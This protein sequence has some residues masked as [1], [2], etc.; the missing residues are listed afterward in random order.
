MYLKK[1]IM[2]GFKSFA[3][4]TV[5]DFEDG[6]TAI[7]GPN[8]S[9]KSNILDALRWVMGEMSAKTLRGAN[10]QQIIFAGTEARKPLNF[11]EVSLVL[12]NTDRA[13]P[14]DFDELVVTR[15]VFR[16]G[17]SVYMI[18]NA[19]CRL[20]DVQE[21]FMDT[22]IGRGGYSMIGQGNVAQILSTKAEDRRDFFEGAAGVSK[23]KHRK[24]EAERKLE[25][26]NDNLTRVNDI[27]AELQSQIGP[28]ENQSKK[29]K[30]Y[31]EYYEEYK[32][33]DVSMSVITLKKNTELAEKAKEA[34]ETVTAEMEDLRAKGDETTRR[35][36]ELITLSKE[37]DEEKEERNRSLS[38]CEEQRLGALNDITIANNN[39]A[40]NTKNAERIDREIELSKKR[41]A[42]MHSQIAA[43]KEKI[44]ENKKT[45][46]EMESGFADVSDRNKA[47]FDAVNE[48]KERLSK[49]REEMS[50]AKETAT[51]KKANIEGAEQMRSEYISRREE[52]T[53]EIS[54]K[55]ANTEQ[56]SKRIAEN[57]KLAKDAEEK[58]ISMQG[59]VDSVNADIGSKND[60][61]QKVIAE[62]SELTVSNNSMTSKKRILEGMENEYEGFARSVKLVLKA[63][64]LK[65]RSIYGTLSGLVEVDKEYVVAIE[66]ALSGALQNIV[67]EDED[68]AKAA[69]RFLKEQHGG[70][71]TFLPISSVKSR[72]LDNERE[73]VSSDGV[74]GI[75]SDLVKCDRKYRG[76]VENL[77]GRTVVADNIDNAITLSKKFG[78]KF[79]TVTIAGEVFNAG[80]SISGGS[81]N[82]QSG[83]LSRAN[84][85][86]ELAEDISK[87]GRRL[88]E[89]AKA[90]EE[91]D[92]EIKNLETRLNSYLPL[93]R[94][95]END[96]MLAKNNAE[97]LKA[98]ML[99]SD[100]SGR[101]LAEQLATIEE[102]LSKSGDE[103]ARLIG[104]QR[105]YE[106]KASELE[107]AIS[108]TEDKLEQLEM[109]KENATASVMEE[110]LKIRSLTSET[111]AE[112]NAITSLLESIAA[113]TEEER[114]KLEEKAAFLA[115][116]ERLTL[117]IDESN[118]KIEEVKRRMELIKL[119]ISEI[120]AEKDKIAE[121]QRKIQESNKEFTD[122][123]VLLQQ[124][125]SRA[126][127]KCEKISTESENIIT[128]LW[129]D[130]EL[131][132]SS[133]EEVKQEIP[134]EK[135]A[136]KR[137]LELKG[138]IKALGSVNMDAIEEYKAVKERFEFLS[139]Q[140][141]DLEAAILNLNKIISSTQELMEEHF[142]KQFAEINKSF[143]RVFTELFGGGRG[144]LYLSDPE[145]VL[146]SGI[147]IEAQLPG[148]TLQNMSL[149]SGGER[150][151]IAT[152]LLFAIL[153]VKPTPF[154]VLDEIDAALDDVNVSRFATYLKNYLEDTQFV[155][156]THRRGTMEA[157]NVLYGVTMQEKGVTKMLS[158]AIDDVSDE[159]LS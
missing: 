81:V 94:E 137:V 40:N 47:V 113:F 64:E 104:E 139:V 41:T 9:G 107:T 109:E 91:K 51:A 15:R 95:Y 73:V 126:E 42:E 44:E 136:A 93:L 125:Y 70:R 110:T 45:V 149:Y 80:G 74:I 79:R 124:E 156:I 77:L 29:A 99:S 90:R 86:K 88:L 102:H 11:A 97:H 18:N 68:D 39:I 115:D 150:S 13:F 71:A 106:R 60:E 133:A 155:V 46:A 119:A 20:R 25:T 140:K 84:E 129:E 100:E 114:S 69:I 57:E 19:T 101:S 49:L 75:A 4:K 8:G 135:E 87:A 34:L 112:Q 56:I 12:D 147:E 36:E 24:E 16:S 72:R 159:M 89:L 122:R 52:I 151:M 32:G 33:L 30:K 120:D 116:N 5:V 26:T 153:A 65:N 111:E 67:V 53:A 21:L 28:L 59:R 62:Q 152:A 23:Y 85:I 17:E 3:D 31:L 138:K 1:I 6:I 14:I 143:Q 121:E 55:E 66:T 158:L 132:V 127:T 123:L 118:E 96:A 148:K 83:F 38:A 27:T 2:Q 82:K 108:E 131:T 117:E 78:Y 35:V 142:N 105:T 103:V 76:I 58:R 98:S 63:Q 54:A 48:Q 10:M 145:N 43:K 144:R 128:R 92:T 154:C 22:G 146:E 50:L 61:L 130:Y 37:K 141:A 7:V 157:A 134:D